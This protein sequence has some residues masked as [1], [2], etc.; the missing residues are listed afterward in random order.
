MVSLTATLFTLQRRGCWPPAALGSQGPCVRE[1]VVKATANAVPSKILGRIRGTSSGLVGQVRRGIGMSGLTIR[2]A[3][4]RTWPTYDRRL[5]DMV[6]GDDR[7]AAGDPAVARPMADLGDRWPHRLPARVLALRLRWWAHGGGA[8]AEGRQPSCPS[9]TAAK[10]T[11]LALGQVAAFEGAWVSSF[12]IVE[13]C[14]DRW[15]LDMLD[16]E[17]RRRWG[18]EERV[19]LRGW[20]IQ[21]VFA[22]DVYHCAELNET[23]RNRRPSPDRSVGVRTSRDGDD[24]V[25]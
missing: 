9:R 13:H 20:V 24:R 19:H 5:P 14:L 6:A 16:E 15:T 21:R 1:S 11:R 3:Y 18:T 8:V 22:H 23:F 2:P 17:I 4:P 12:R 10:S 7:G 25:R